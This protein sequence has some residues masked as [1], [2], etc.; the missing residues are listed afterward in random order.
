VIL[1]GFADEAANDKT[2][3][4]QMAVFAALGLDYFSLR[5]IDTGDGVKNVMQ[6]DSQDVGRIKKSMD[7]YD[8][9]VSSIGSPIGKVKLLDVDDGT[10]NQYYEFD[11][12]L[13][14]QV[15]KACQLA[16]QFDSKLIRG[17][18]FYH[19]LGTS[20]SEHIELVAERLSAIVK[21]CDEHGLNFGLELEANL[22]GQSAELLC[23]IHQ[24]VNHPALMLIFDGGNLVTQG[25]S[26][27]EIIAQYQSMKS[28][29]GWM[30]IKDYRH[31][32][33][34]T[35]IEHVD[36]ESLR[37]FVPASLGQSGHA[38][39]LESM[40]MDLPEIESRLS[41][42]GLPGFFIDMEPHVRG[43][44]QFGGF[45]GP[46][47]FGIALRDFCSLLDNAGIEY[48]LREYSDIAK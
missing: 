36:E 34:V 1:T 31:P 3:D 28:R 11:A 42:R 44:G 22:V 18:S 20:P 23:E 19:P 27:S 7:E 35:R 46:D 47:G 29:M 4:Q 9:R 6:L 30:H 38:E 10:Q 14:N 16:V 48:R 45:S 33:E 41:K 15:L 24:L 5:F 37:H 25:Y 26:T 2:I 17:F 12:Y 39:I 21:I 32:H 43:G 8:L 13:E 40:R